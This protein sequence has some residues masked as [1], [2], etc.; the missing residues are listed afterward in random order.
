MFVRHHLKVLIDNPH[1][2]AAGH[3]V[4]LGHSVHG[5]GRIPPD[6]GSDSFDQPAS[7]HGMFSPLTGLPQGL[8]SLPKHFFGTPDE[9]AAH[10]EGLDDVSLGLVS[11]QH[12]QDSSF[13]VCEVHISVLNAHADLYVKS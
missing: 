13:L 12:P 10:P 6:L 8:A 9:H 11:I 3:V 7:P 2:C 1:H 5:V 4:L